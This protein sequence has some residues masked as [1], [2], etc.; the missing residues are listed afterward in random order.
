MLKN[1][2]WKTRYLNSEGNVH[3]TRGVNEEAQRDTAMLAITG[4]TQRE[5]LKQVAVI[6]KDMWTDTQQA[7]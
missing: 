7:A 3:Q 4:H 1:Q 2:D 6:C 5:P